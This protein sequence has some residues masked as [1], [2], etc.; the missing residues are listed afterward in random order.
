MNKS[1][2]R[3]LNSECNCPTYAICSCVSSVAV[4]RL[5]VCTYNG[6]LIS[7]KCAL[8]QQRP[9]SSH[10][11]SSQD[12]RIFSKAAV[13]TCSLGEKSLTDSVARALHG[14][15]ASLR[16]ASELS[17]ADEEMQSQRCSGA[18]RVPLQ[19]SASFLNDY[20]SVV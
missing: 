11:D 10:S 18:P 2:P 17:L 14:S 15:A 5:H 6:K 9:V 8:C 7:K 3:P 1:S 16:P 19:R 20:L 4:I 12:T 13:R